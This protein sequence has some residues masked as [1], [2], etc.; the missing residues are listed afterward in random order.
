LFEVGV[1]KEVETLTRPERLLGYNQ[2]DDKRA[3][4]AQDRVGYSGWGRS[5][6]QGLGRSED[7]VAIQMILAGLPQ[8]GPLHKGRVA[9]DI[10][11][12]IEQQG[13]NDPVIFH[14]LGFRDE[15]AELRR[16]E[17]FVSRRVVKSTR[18]LDDIPG[19][20][21]AIRS[22]GGKA[23]PILAVHPHGRKNEGMVVVADWERFLVWH[24]FSPL[25]DG[26]DLAQLHEML[27]VDVVDLNQDAVRR[28]QILTQE[29]DWLKGVEDKEGYLRGRVV[30]RVL[31]SFDIEIS[32][33]SAGILLS[34]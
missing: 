9:R 7:E 21:G 31:E 30:V 25:R 28:G 4:I 33:K 24:Q 8:V 26:D 29:P 32:D 3:F 6:G 5:Y 23:I 22:A 27:L 19:Y 10:L 1:K 2:I 11:D 13:L 18:G 20:I 14:M 12:A 15:E 17:F 16:S 34:L